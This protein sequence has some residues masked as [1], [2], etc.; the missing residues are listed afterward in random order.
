MEK[1]NGVRSSKR[2]RAKPKVDYTEIT[3]LSEHEELSKLCTIQEY[4]IRALRR[5]IK[6]YQQ[7]EEINAFM[8]I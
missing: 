1:P 4:K 3:H 5:K 2:L 7:T 8:T 6:F